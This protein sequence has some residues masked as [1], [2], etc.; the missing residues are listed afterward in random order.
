MNART[1]FQSMFVGAA[2]SMLMLL[3]WS[4]TNTSAMATQSADYYYLLKTSGQ[5]TPII[6]VRRAGGG[7]GPSSGQKSEDVQASKD[8]LE[9][10]RDRKKAGMDSIQKFLDIIRSMNP[11]L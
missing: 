5:G 4:V 3:F 11:Q 8:T 7:P 6:L 9:A 10:A 1:L 2:L